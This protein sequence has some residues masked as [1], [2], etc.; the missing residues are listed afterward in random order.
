MK[1]T[2]MLLAVSLLLVFS[3]AACGGSQTNG[4]ADSYDTAGQT[5]TAG[6]GSGVTGNNGATG[7]GM[8]GSDG[9]ANGGGTTVNNGVSGDGLMDDAQN[10]LDNAGRAARN[11]VDNDARNF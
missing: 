3:L 4:A 6:T 2:L 7:S 8:I 9:T 5:G 10:A 11:T 1:N